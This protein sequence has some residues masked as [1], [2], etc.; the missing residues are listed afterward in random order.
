MT[1][2]QMIKIMNIYVNFL[3]NISKCLKNCI[4]NSIAQPSRIYSRYARLIQHSKIHQC[5]P[6]NRKF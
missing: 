5:N 3:K 1:S 6:I 4:K 2:I